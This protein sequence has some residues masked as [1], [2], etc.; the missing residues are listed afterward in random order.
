LKVTDLTG[1]IVDN[2]LV[3]FRVESQFGGMTNVLTVSVDGQI[4]S[5]QNIT[6]A[7]DFF[8]IIYADYAGSSS[9]ILV[10]I[11]LPPELVEIV[12]AS[13]NESTAANLKPNQT[14][15]LMLKVT[16][17]ENTSPLTD[18]T[19]DVIGNAKAYTT[20]EL[21]DFDEK[22]YS[23]ILQVNDNAVTGETITLTAKYIIDGGYIVSRPFMVTVL[24]AVD[25]VVIINAPESL[26]LGESYTLKYRTE[27][28]ASRLAVFEFA[29]VAYQQSA[30]LN[31]DTGVLTIKDDAALIGYSIKVCVT[32]DGASS[33]DYVINI[34]D[35]VREITIGAAMESTG[36]QYIDEY[37]FYVLY[38]NGEFVI[39]QETKGGGFNPQLNF[40]L[41]V[42]GQKN[43]FI[44]GNTVT[45]KKGIDINSGINATVMAT[46]DGVV[47][48][49]LVIY[50]PAVITTPGE[51][52]AIQNNI[53]GYYVLGND[54]YFTDIEYKSIRMFAGIIDGAGF[55]LR[56]INLSS[57]TEN[58]N[59]GLIEENYGIIV[60]LSVRQLTVNIASAPLYG[61][62][63]YIGGIVSRN[64]GHIINCKTVS[65]G[66]NMMYILVADSY[67]SGIAGLNVGNIT[68]SENWIYIQ[69][70]GRVG[71][72]AGLNLDGGKITNSFNAELLSANKYDE[73]KA[74]VGIVGEI[75]GG[76]VMNCENYGKVFDMYRWDY[77][78]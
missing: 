47:S 75:R 11:L 25:H 3:T 70:V 43:L 52:F 16:A 19:L 61:G 68:L 50:I 5:K 20:V 78:E 6:G 28:E 45:V 4:N 26:N 17:E 24:R 41:D 18:I 7:D 31:A 57:I 33:I 59:V 67:A 29:D 65:T 49:L 8:A 30:T 22:I 1:A 34:K 63:V 60:N 54:I 51:W 14:A 39:S 46:K 77:V 38:P 13:D 69:T 10:E 40:V 36:V 48:N 56:D 73:S 74:I 12:L 2:S 64:Y 37:E 27:P 44:T 23:I 32:V 71:G 35:V 21:G 72:I 42:I 62:T 15:E 76:T 55:A 58:N 53:N 9:Y 66:V